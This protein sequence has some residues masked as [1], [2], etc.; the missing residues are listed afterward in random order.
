MW[1]KI[2]NL[3]SDVDPGNFLK[4]KN[5]LNLRL[6][7]SVYY[8]LLTR[9][10]RGIRTLDTLLRYTHFPGV[11]LQPLGH[12]SFKGCKSN[13]FLLNVNRYYSIT[14]TFTI[15]VFPWLSIGIA[16]VLINVSPFLT[17]F[18]FTSRSFTSK[19]VSSVLSNLS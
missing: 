19:I 1:L 5:A 15:F 17:S 6:K 9:G 14:V 11:L 7:R 12:L 13:I 4:Q 16:A 10:E 3:F 18:I 8:T 2:Y